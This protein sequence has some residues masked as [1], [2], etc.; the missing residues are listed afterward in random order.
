MISHADAELQLAFA[1]HLRDPAQPIPAGLDPARVA[2]YRR[3]FFNNVHSILSANFPVISAILDNEWAPLVRQFYSGFQ[4]HVPLFTELAREFV[5]FLEDQP[6]HWQER[7]P[8]LRDLAHY[9]WVELELMLDPADPNLLQVDREGD[10]WTGRPVVSP[11]V[12]L[13]AYAWPVH[14]I[15]PEF[16]PQES[17]AEPVF[18][19]VYRGRKDQIGFMALNPVSARLLELLADPK[20][21]SGAEAM[22]GIA[23]ALGVADPQTLW[24]MARQQLEQWLERDILLGVAASSAGH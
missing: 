18:L 19:L 6:D 15:R 4:S 13:L 22:A 23:A 7:W 20:L 14:Q 3:L 17:P 5:R 21:G 8:F 9:E 16:Q 11:C 2:T 24:P 1:R 10:L 12:R